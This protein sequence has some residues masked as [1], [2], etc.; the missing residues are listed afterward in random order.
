MALKR[1]LKNCVKDAEVQ[2]S[3]ADDFCRG[4]SGEGLS[5]LYMDGHWEPDH[6]PVSVWSTQ[7]AL[8]VLRGGGHK[9]GQT[10]EDW[11]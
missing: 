4:Y 11:E 1:T 9:G 3:T 6:A 8:G 2:L 10:Q 7:V 5:F